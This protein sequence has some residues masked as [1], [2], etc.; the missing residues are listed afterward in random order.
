MKAISFHSRLLSL[1]ADVVVV[2]AILQLVTF[3][4]TRADNSMDFDHKYASAIQTMENL[5]AGGLEA[6]VGSRRMGSVLSCIKQNGKKEKKKL[7]KMFSFLLFFRLI[8]D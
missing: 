8:C 7:P 2:V 6:W 4:L 5:G 3:V 1:T